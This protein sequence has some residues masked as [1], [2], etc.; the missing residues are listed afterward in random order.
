MRELRLYSGSTGCTVELGR[1]LGERA[2]AGDVVALRGDLG[3]GKTVLARGVA[4]GLGVPEPVPV[5]SPT[6]TL[7]NE[8]E[9]RLRLYHID[10][11]RLGEPDELETLPWREALFGEGVAVIEWPE[12]M[13]ERLPEERLEIV[14]EIAGDDERRILLRGSGDTMVNRVQNWKD[15]LQDLCGDSALREKP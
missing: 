4:R 10:L 1:F 14:L 2:E 5:T 11:Y 3:A 8:Y 12:R 7:I 15:R 13:E 9:A 6:F